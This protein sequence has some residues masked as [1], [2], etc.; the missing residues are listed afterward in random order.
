MRDD[1]TRKIGKEEDEDTD[2]DQSLDRLRRS[3][4]ERTPTKMYPNY[5]LY[6]TVV[7][8]NEF[9]L[10]TNGDESNDGDSGDRSNGTNDA[11]IDNKALG[12]VAHYVMVHYAEKEMLK[13]IKRRDASPKLGNMHWTLDLGS[14][15]AEV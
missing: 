3:G 13:R 6:I 11:Q 1:D 12:A 9:L 2:T 10:A 14:L 4:R 15:V 5:K 7:E 8:E